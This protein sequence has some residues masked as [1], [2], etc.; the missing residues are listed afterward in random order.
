MSDW[1]RT[2]YDDADR[3][4]AAAYSKHFAPTASFSLANNPPMT[5]PGEIEAGLKGFFGTIA[6]MRH[7]F[8]HRYTEG[9]VEV[10]EADVTYTRLD[11]ST[12]TVPGAAV[13]ERDGDTIVA[14]RSYVDIAPL[15]AP[16]SE[17]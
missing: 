8:T 3:L 9:Q 17:S 14:M 7:T 5:G 10:M 6:G 11:G 1:V 13:I 4:D 2:V 15:F 12:V 16:A